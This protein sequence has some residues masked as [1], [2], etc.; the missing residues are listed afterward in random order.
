MS[1]Y[2]TATVDTNNNNSTFV[3][4]GIHG[5]IELKNVRN[6]ISKNG[7]SFLSFDFE[8]KQGDKLFK[9]LWEIKSRKPLHEMN[10]QEKSNFEFRISNQ[11]AL[12]K[13]IIETYIPKGSYKEAEVNSFKEFAN[14][15]V[16]TLNNKYEGE[17]VRVKVV[18]DNKNY[19]T[20][21][22]NPR[23]V[24][25]EKMCPEEESKIRLLPTDKVERSLPDRESV[26]SN[27]IST[28]SNND[29]N[30]SNEDLPF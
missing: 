6:E 3:P 15:V 14:W 17:K 24:F 20:L 27:P 9:T 8:N 23:S 12:V 21:P 4:V 28:S 13:Q 16:S 2:N 26:R 5:D 25:I 29:I 7:N 1:I 11:I 10:E 30:K 22:D 18:Y 19:T